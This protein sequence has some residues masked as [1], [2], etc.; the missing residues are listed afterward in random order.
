MGK[1]ERGR[2]S[3]VSG[4]IGSRE[5]NDTRWKDNAVVTVA[6]TIYGQHPTGKVKRW[7][8]KDNTQV[9]I[10]IPQA[11]Q[12]YNS[13]MSGTDRMDQNIKVVV[14]FVHVDVSFSCSECLANCKVQ[15]NIY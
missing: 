10:P 7:S 14:E 8:K 6:S 5:V 11:L 3:S 4:R 13:N 9:M 12:A 2:C 15:R 1:K